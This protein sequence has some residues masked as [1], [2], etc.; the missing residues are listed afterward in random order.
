MQKSYIDRQPEDLI[1]ALAVALNISPADLDLRLKIFPPPSKSPLD[2]L[3]K[4]RLYAPRF[5]TSRHRQVQLRPGLRISTRNNRA[6][7]PPAMVGSGV[8]QHRRPGQNTGR[9]TPMSQQAVLPH[10]GYFRY[11]ER[12]AMRRSS[13]PRPAC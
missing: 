11:P 8:L 12:S 9:Q 3:Y 4:P 1:A 5:I 10:H 13:P 6:G 7:R 2:L